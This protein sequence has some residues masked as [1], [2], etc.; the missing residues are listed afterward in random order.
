MSASPSKANRSVTVPDFVKAKSVG[1]KLS[2]LTA[3]DA[4]WARMF[5]E[6]DVDAL[7]VGDSLG[8]VVQGHQTTL[9]VTLDEIIY[10]AKMVT[11]VTERALV[12]VDLPYMTY[13]VSNEQAVMSAGRILKETGASAVKLEGGQAQAEAIAALARVEIPV[14]A[15]VGMRPQS[16]RKFGRHS[17]IQRDADQLLAD[18]LA[19]EQ[20]GAFSVVLEL[21]PRSIAA[22]ITRQLS[23]PTIGIG[24]GP[25]CDGQVLVSPDMLG[26]TGFRPKFVKPYA[27]LREVVQAAV[28]EYC[29]EVRDGEFP[30]DTHSHQ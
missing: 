28:R 13:Q 14:M 27:Q 18:A 26:L 20:A 29:Q 24:A 1:R 5:D 2:M 9:P 21:I 7:L 23:I 25:D 22:E 11:R 12:V 6:S 16:I 15:H 30:N 19:A 8:M 10:H 3:Y 17:A 4:L